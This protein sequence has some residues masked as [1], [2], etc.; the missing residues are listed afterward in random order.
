MISDLKNQLIRS[1][2]LEGYLKSKNAISVFQNLPREDFMPQ[3][4][5]NKYEDRPFSIG[6][7]ATISAPHMHAIALELLEPKLSTSKSCLDVGSGT[8][9]LK[10][11]KLEYL[12]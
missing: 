10:F 11:L 3:S 1:L 2:R 6:Y 9:Y 12:H 8:G 7:N 5:S 4:I